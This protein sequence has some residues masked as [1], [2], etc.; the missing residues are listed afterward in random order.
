MENHITNYIFTNHLLFAQ[1]AATPAIS[2]LPRK[3]INTS[4]NYWHL[5]IGYPNPE[6]IISLP[7][8]TVDYY[9]IKDI[10]KN[11]FD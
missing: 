7:N 5:I 4:P 6:I 11:A 2:Y 3:P 9:I 8:A 10:I 1:L